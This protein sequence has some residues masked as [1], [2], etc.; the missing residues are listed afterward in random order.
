MDSCKCNEIIPVPADVCVDISG[1]LAGGGSVMVDALPDVGSAVPNVIYV[2]RSTGAAWMT[3]DNVSYIAVAYESEQGAITA[4]EDRLDQMDTELGDLGHEIQTTNTNLSS[5]ASTVSNLDS[6]IT[7]VAAALTTHEG[8][9]DNPHQVTK[10]QVGL[11]NVNNT[12]DADKPVSTAQATALATKQ[13]KQ[14]TAVSGNL[15]EWNAAGQTIDSGIAADDI[16]AIQTDILNIGQEITD[17]G[18]DI[19]DVADDLSTHEGKT[20]NPHLVTKDQ[21]GLGNVNNTSDADKP[22]STAT[23]TALSAKQ[24]KQTTAVSG[25]IATFDANGQTVDSGIAASAIT[26][27][28]SAISTINSQLTSIN[29]EIS[30]IENTFGDYVPISESSGG[31]EVTVTNDGTKFLAEVD[32]GNHK[33]F[34]RVLDGEVDIIAKTDQYGSEG[35]LYAL[36]DIACVERKKV[37]ADGSFISQQLY[38]EDGNTRPQ[39]D[40]KTAPAGGSP[41]SNDVHEIAF[42]DDVDTVA[43]AA[44]TAQS[45]ADTAVTDAATAN[46]AAGTAQAAADAAQTTANT[47]VTNA[48]AAQT[49]ADSAQTAA[50][51]AQATA[52]TALTNAATAQSTADTAVSNAATAQATADS[53]VT[54]A[55]AAQSTADG[56]QDPLTFDNTPTSGSTNPVTSGGIFTALSSKIDTLNSGANVTITGSGNERTISVSG[57]EIPDKFSSTDSVSGA[58]GTAVTGLSQANLTAINAGATLSV[59]DV[60]YTANGFQVS[61]TA[62]NGSTTYDGVIISIQQTISFEN[63]A[64]N[65]TDNASLAGE[66]GDKQ[67]NLT[68]DQLAATNSG[69][70]SA[71]VSGYD[72]HITDTAIHVTSTDK[73]TWNDKQAALTA[74]QLAATNSGIT[75]SKVSGYDSHVNDTDIHVTATNKQTWNDKQ[76]ALTSDQLAATN[77]GI[78]ST[79]VSEY[80]SHITDTDI[81]VTSTDKQ[82]W[83]D[84]QNALTTTQLAATNSGITSSKVSTYDTHVDDQTIHVTAANKQTWS[85]KQN[86][87]TADQLSA[88]NSGITATKV[89]G[90]DSHVGNTDIHV[91]ATDKQTWDG[92]QSALTTDQLAATNSGITAAKVTAYDEHITDTDIHVTL[93]EKQTWGSKQ[94][95]LTADQL[96][97]VNSGITSSKVSTYDTTVTTLSSHTG[98][99]AI[100]VTAT[101]K[102]A[103]NAKQDALSADQLSAT[104]SGITAADKTK[105]D[106]IAT[107]AN[108][109]VIITA[110]SENVS[111][112]VLTITFSSNPTYKAVQQLSGTA[113][114]TTWVNTSG[115]TWTATIPTTSMEDYMLIYY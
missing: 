78:T 5:L 55:A 73:Q 33:T 115:T 14:T 6:N 56:K 67:D 7:N 17:L 100:H 93:T 77:S 32:N 48:A 54:A 43:T 51:S 19:Q 105:L 38:M 30:V 84:K 40:Y 104:N 62:I 64:G 59:D 112:G 86:A 107:G 53:A 74:D 13:D 65:A 66:L 88:T 68:S 103:W 69:I 109:T 34:A 99:S 82:T 83:S 27:N 3:G 28:A 61:V 90:Y 114:T 96:S 81:H 97:A 29:S 89:S 16:T 58:V 37:N 15:A 110:F 87:L 71:K 111:T 44:A 35:A 106:G 11:G 2:L 22:V 79:K 21:V 72:S 31:K 101:E 18:T 50:D 57:I 49:T 20:D 60:I 45:T 12:S 23:A 10:D 9:T 24:D 46:A 63:I 25:D 8:K 91:T 70:T 113:I 94:S 52:N 1:T 26:D 102:S 95:A 42:T 108:K 47:A 80:D 92:K 85:D 4:I 76:A 98:N 41:V 36:D 39:F 75:S